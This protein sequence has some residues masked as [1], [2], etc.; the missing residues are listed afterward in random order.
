M[1]TIEKIDNGHLNLSEFSE[2][3]INF[4]K[5]IVKMSYNDGFEEG[6]NK[7]KSIVIKSLEEE[8]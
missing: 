5:G 4:I 8:K 6:S 3:Q 7:I 2:S 1:N